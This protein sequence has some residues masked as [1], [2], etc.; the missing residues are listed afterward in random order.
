MS[1]REGN[2]RKSFTGFIAYY[3]DGR[4]LREKEN[5]TDSNGKNHATNWFE[6]K[7]DK[8]VALELL[9][10]GESK[11]SIAKDEY[12]FIKA[13]DWFFSQLGYQD[14]S[15]REIKV[16]ARNIG[17]V[18]DGILQIFTVDEDN[19]NLRISTRDA[20]AKK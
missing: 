1:P 7:K 20:K 10:R 14:M 6:I 2:S 18:K 9:W 3:D 19:G 4:K 16:I 5:Y 15:N 11:I 8:L 13:D 12:P 17:Y